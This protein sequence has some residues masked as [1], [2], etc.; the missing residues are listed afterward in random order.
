MTTMDLSSKNSC[1]HHL[2]LAGYVLTPL[3]GKVPTETNWTMAE[4][5]PLFTEEDFPANYG[6]VLQSDDLIIDVDP[7]NFPKNQDSFQLLLTN[8]QADPFNT[9]TVKTGA[10]GL[11]IYLKKPPGIITRSSHP[12]FK[13]VEF[14]TKG[15][16][17][18]GPG[19]IHPGTGNEYKVLKGNPYRIAD[20]PLALLEL[21][22]LLDT[23]KDGHDIVVNSRAAMDRFRE[24]LKRTEGAVEGQN[25]DTTTYKLAQRGLDLGLDEEFVYDL[26]LANWNDKCSPPWTSFQLRQKVE[27]AARY[28]QDRIGSSTAQAQFS[29]LV[30][31]SAV[32]ETHEDGTELET[33]QD[34]QRLAFAQV[35]YPWVLTQQMDPNGNQLLKNT[36]LRNV[37]NV[38][39]IP[40]YKSYTNPLYKMLRFNEMTSLVEKKYPAPW[41]TEESFA[42]GWTDTDTAYLK[43][44]LNENFSFYPTDTLILQGIGLAA[45]EC[46]YHPVRDYLKGL[47]WDGES[48]IEKLLPY[49]AGAEDNPY[50]RTIARKMMAAAVAKIMYMYDPKHPHAEKGVKFDHMMILEGEQGIGKSTFCKI[51]GGNWY[52]DIQFDLKNFKDTVAS[53]KSNWIIE[54]SEF[55]AYSKQ[56]VSELKAFMTQQFDVVRLP[57][58]RTPSEIIRRYVCFATY[59]PQG[60][61][62]YLLDVT[63]N[64]RFWPVRCYN[65][66]NEELRRDRDQLWAEAVALWAGGEKLYIEDPLANGMAMV[67]QNRR[68]VVDVWFEPI[69]DYISRRFEGT[70]EPQVVTVIDAA[71]VALGMKV[72][73]ISQ[74]DRNRIEA[75][76]TTMNGIPGQHNVQFRGLV[77]GFKFHKQIERG[78]ENASI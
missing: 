5:D 78:V 49:Y 35:P 42:T 40:D 34:H 53:Y 26:M 31:A 37:T 55:A 36:A 25:G 28:R 32:A 46:R 62:R 39:D 73:R 19:S 50:T 58:D 66:R 45:N 71:R 77:T 13:G 30:G 7:R 24:L 3:S 12:S 17:V 44:Y 9:F 70:E 22:Q 11:H 4:Y 18:V 64:R 54:C 23:R 65:F 21:L 20:A 27:N 43:M 38:F 14:K 57:Y 1:I 75:V 10:N 16:Q 6:V 68:T 47:K 63:G 8:I 69:A 29:D 52:A 74:A 15:N 33:L 72:A 76:L 67:A 41:D 48:R 59:N 51:L 61:G 2:S 60:T 56:D